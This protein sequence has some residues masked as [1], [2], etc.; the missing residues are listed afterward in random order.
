MA[1]NDRWDGDCTLGPFFD[2]DGD[3]IVPCT[4]EAT[5]EL[6]AECMG[7]YRVFSNLPVVHGSEL[8]LCNRTLTRFIQENWSEVMGPKLSDGFLLAYRS[9]HKAVG[10]LAE[11]VICD[12]VTEILRRSGNGINQRFTAADA[13]RKGLL[14]QHARGRRSDD[15]LLAMG[16]G[17]GCLVESKA[18]FSGTEYLRRSLPKA[19]A[20]LR[21]TAALNRNLESVLLVL[22]GIRQKEIVVARLALHDLAAG[23]VSDLVMLVRRLLPRG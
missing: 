21:A 16:N 13:V 17:S 7:Y 2:A 1:H 23:D 9:P 10:R 8:L 12:Q 6:L 20:Q 15:L 18:S 3:E 5:D 4:T 19:F 22:T 11:D 14:I